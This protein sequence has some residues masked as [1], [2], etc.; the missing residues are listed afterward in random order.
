MG[1][2]AVSG[3]TRC[4]VWHLAPQT[5]IATVLPC[6]S[7]SPGSMAGGL[8]SVHRRGPDAQGHKADTQGRENTGLPRPGQC[9]FSLHLVPVMCRQEVGGGTTHGCLPRFFRLMDTFS[10]KRRV[11]PPPAKAA[12]RELPAVHSPPSVC[13]RPDESKPWGTAQLHGSGNFL[14]V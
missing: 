2:V 9:P 5:F 11:T 10:A 14:F 6:V 4:L 12:S 1:T 7:N 3:R 8:L 13:P